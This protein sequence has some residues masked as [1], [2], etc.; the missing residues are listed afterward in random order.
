VRTVFPA[1]GRRVWYDDQRE[2]HSQ[3]QRGD[4][5]ID[6]A[7]MGDDPEA[8]DNRLLREAMQQSVP[9]LYFLGVAPQRYTLIWPTYVV[10]WSATDLKAQLAF[11]APFAVASA[12]AAPAAPERR[13]ALRLVRQRLHQT[14]F[15]EAVMTAYGS[16]CAISGLP[17]P[18]LLDAAHI[19]DDG[20]ETLGQPVVT[21]GLPLSK[22]HHAAFDANLIGID[23]DF[24]IH[25]SEA[26]LFMHDGPLFEQAIRAIDGQS[27]RRP[28]RK[29]D[30]PDRDRLAERFARFQAMR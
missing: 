23:P 3:I 20:D 6:Y 15:R 30:C 8:H 13:Y 16:R 1:T 25:I 7:F 21:N 26:L 29:Q 28:K 19:V 24:R 10:E 2:V 18:R 9:V 5:L 22:L 4:E 14:T 27:I 17:E 11:G 12:W